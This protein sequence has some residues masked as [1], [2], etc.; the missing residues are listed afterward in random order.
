MYIMI[1]SN[2][3]LISLIIILFIT[4]I[5]RIFSANESTVNTDRVDSFDH[6]IHW[7]S[8]YS[9]NYQ[10][11]SCRKFI[12]M[13]IKGEGLGDMLTRFTAGV[14]MAYSLKSTL[15]LPSRFWEQSFHDQYN[16][17]IFE[18]QLGIPLSKF[19]LLQD[20]VSLYKPVVATDVLAL[21]RVLYN[22]RLYHRDMECNSLHHTQAYG[23]TFGYRENPFTWCANA[24]SSTIQSIIRPFLDE[25]LEFQQ[26]N[27]SRIFPLKKHKVNVVWHIRT[28]DVCIRCSK[29]TGSDFFDILSLFIESSLKPLQLDYHNIVLLKEKDKRIVD[30]LDASE[31]FK[32]IVYMDNLSVEK[33]IEIMK[34]CDI[35]VSTGEYHT[36]TQ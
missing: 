11:T 19:M 14:A 2:S 26:V 27:K 34:Q 36:I 22:P 20:V 18:N 25:S 32:N 21:D 24:L 33:A 7:K 23:C 13:E 12:V 16:T 10:S 3:C 30:I 9:V 15:V 8:V 4:N 6:S 1:H 35:L 29:D 17:S 31:V 28:G 5:I